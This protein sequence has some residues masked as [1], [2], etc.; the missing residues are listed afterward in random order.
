MSDTQKRIAEYKKLL[1]GLKERVAAVA[2]LLVISITMVTTTTFA[3]V[4]LS[5]SP[6]VT[7]VTTNIASN[8]N[9]EIALVT[10]DGTTAPGESK[11][12]DSSASENQS[13][14]GANVTWGNMINLNDPAYGLENLV[15]RPAQLNTTALLTSPLYGAEYGP[16]GRITQLTSDFAY[17]TWILPEG[18][19]PGYF[20]VSDRLGVRAISSTKIEAVGAEAKYVKMVSTARNDNITA[21]NHY[22]N[23]VNKPGYMPSLATMMGLYMTAR[24]NPDDGSLSNPDCAVAD[25]Q[26][27]RD[28]YADFLEAFDLE[29]QAM[30]SLLNLQLFLKYGDGNYTP[31][32]AEM[33][34]ATTSKALKDKG[35]QITNLDQFLKDRN[36]IASDHAKLVEIAESGTSLK[37]KDSG[38]NS[39]VNNLVDVGKCTIGADNTPI[40]SIGASNAMNYLSGTQEAKITN[41][42]L[43]RFEE[44]TGGY[45]QVKNLG[46]SATVKRM[47][48]TIPATVKANIQTTAPRD[49]TLFG[50]DL[51][52]AE[53]MNDGNYEGGEPVAQ[54]TFGLAVDFWVRT[55]AYAHSLVL[56]GN[57]L[58]EEEEVRAM[59][60]DPNGNEVELYSLARSGEEK[61]EAGNSVPYSYSLTLYK[62]VTTD[63]SGNEIEIWYNL[64]THAE[65]ILGNDELPT[66]KMETIVTVIGYDGANR[67]WTGENSAMLS[68]DNTTQ[69]SGSC[70]VYYADTPEDQARSLKLLEAMKV[71]FVDS[72]GKLLASAEMDTELFFAQNGKVIV[73]MKLNPSESTKVDEGVYAITTLEQNVATRIT[74]IVYLD[75]TKLTNDDVL[76]AADI[77]GQL[78]IQFGA[79]QPDLNNMDNEELMNKV[80]R[81]SA[82]VDQT[83]FDYDA[84]TE[85][86][87]TQVEVTVDGTTPN[88][89]TAFFLR[90]ISA[91]QGSREEVMTFT[92][93]EATGKWKSDYTF[94]A[95]GRYVLRSVRLDGVEYDLTIQPVVT[96]TGFAVTSLSCD[97]ATG[98]RITAMTANNTYPFNMRLRFATDN[99]AKMPTTVQGRFLKDDDGSA[100]N[101]NFTYNATTGEWTGSSAFLTSGDYTMRYLVLDGEYTELD[102]TLWQTA[103]VTLGMRAAVYTTSPHEFLYKSSGMAENEKKLGMQVKL[104]DNGGNELPGLDN[105]KLT[106]IMEGSFSEKMDADLTWNGSY[107]VGEFQTTGAGVW[108]FLNANVGS[109]TITYATT[110]PIFSI[111]SNEPPEYHGTETDVMKIEYAP[112]KDATMQNIF[113]TNTEMA[114]VQA[115]LVKNGATDGVWVDG[116][117]KTTITEEDGIKYTAWA[118]TIPGD[119]EGYQDGIW[120]VTQLKIWKAK[121]PDGSDYTASNPLIIDVSEEEIKTKAINRIVVTFDTNQ[122]QDFGKDGDGNITGTFMQ[123]HTFSGLSVK[124][125][126]FEGAPITGVSDVKLTFAYKNGSSVNYGGYS[127]GL[128][129]NATAGATVTVD[130]TQVDDS[131]TYAQ[132]STEATIQYAGIY[133]T[134]LSFVMDNKEYKYAGTKDDSENG[135]KA[136]PANAPVFTVWSK[137]PTVTIDSISP[138]GDHKSMAVSGNNSKLLDVNSSFTGNTVTIYANKTNKDNGTIDTTPQVTLR[139]NDLG[140]AQSANL[141]FTASGGGTV[142][143]YTG[144]GMSGRTD[145]YSWTSDS[146]T[147]RLYIGQYKSSRTCSSMTYEGAGTLTSNSYI[148][149]TYNNVEYTVAIDPITI[150]NNNPPY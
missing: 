111:W 70:Y 89:V 100:V 76:A 28:M 55:N 78:N 130:L 109:N 140:N 11:V 10:G 136:L 112:N 133:I 108:K 20:G 105:V 92:K 138:S 142:Y 149:I 119:A 26:N 87:K 36:T 129:N 144:T 82:S 113:I 120:Q 29:A 51:K 71:A 3:W 68:T 134:S 141:K 117:R 64:D 23:L 16:D 137:A 35:L 72:E 25:I 115:Y 62:K 32:T 7:G 132:S 145:T 69:G 85:P 57:V 84:T 125:G 143:M 81:V 83:S 8:G 33:V 1:P 114:S 15:L 58:T 126:D 79:Y 90:S 41:G 102:D 12:G 118:F 75:G 97:Q 46:I 67:V 22:L 131:A 121:A 40:S 122:S 42:I 88:T 53:D 61:D 37:W 104:Y 59:G 106:Y 86:M 95:P 21:A 94:T 98:S 18:D 63:D 150:I 38:L 99:A 24:M 101:I 74:A 14:V 52:Y 5:R 116:T 43:Y 65:E 135:T 77:Q 60:K 80:L 139:L 73:P 110:S 91:T 127:S 48:I 103:T 17:A 6:E 45:I 148:T 30:A 39:I 9:L 13:I 56:E 96:V 107:Y 124:I 50:N 66:P 128:L 2:L 49:Y 31:Y 123:T 4:V 147:Y 19:K 47:G 44:R 27:L 34:C 54:D 93:D 146:L